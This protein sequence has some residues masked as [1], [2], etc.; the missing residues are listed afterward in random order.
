MMPLMAGLLVGI[1][2]ALAVSR[3]LKTLLF[4]VENN[5]PAV[6]GGI[7]LLFGIAALCATYLPARKAAHIDPMRT[8]RSE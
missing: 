3:V 8:L 4:G 7:A 1:A 2:G 6:Y 5:D